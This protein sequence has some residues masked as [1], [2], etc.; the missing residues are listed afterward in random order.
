MQLL[1]VTGPLLTMVVLR[2]PMQLLFLLSLAC[3]Y[4]ITEASNLRHSAHRQLTSSSILWD[5]NGEP[6]VSSG[7]NTLL[8]NFTDVGYKAGN[9]AIP[10]WPI[11]VSINDFGAFPD[12]DISD[13]QA[14]LDAVAACPPFSAV[15]IP[16]GRYIID[17]PVV[18]DSSLNNIVIRG[19]S[20]D[21]AILF[22][23]KHMSEVL[24]TAES[25]AYFISFKG[26]TNRGIENLSL[27]L[28]DE[29]KATGYFLGTYLF[30]SLTISLSTQ[31]H[32]RGYNFQILQRLNKR[33][34]IGF[35][36]EKVC[37][38]WEMVNRTVGFEI[39]ISKM[40]TTLFESLVVHKGLPVFLS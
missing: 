20:R 33:N 17:Q 3:S 39:S 12:D 28:R 29:Q 22:F 1:T 30:E 16:N 15:F 24:Q 19:E 7:G 9:E 2:F 27:V 32:S 26:G 18:F 34:A 5:S 4:C 38:A 36:L 37:L 8:R 14:L 21:G 13:V 11:G 6:W 35:D 25:A 40:P 31:V 23:P 10:Q